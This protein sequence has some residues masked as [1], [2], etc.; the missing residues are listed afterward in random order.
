M[1]KEKLQ[2]SLFDIKSI[3][4]EGVVEVELKTIVD[5]KNRVVEVRDSFAKIKNSNFHYPENQKPAEIAGIGESQSGTQSPNLTLNDSIS[6]STIV[7]RGNV[8]N[9]YSLDPRGIEPPRPN[10]QG[11]TRPR[12]GPRY[13]QYIRKN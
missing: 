11:W 8:D 12:P 1:K 13:V 7:S 5:L 4:E 9:F 10:C 6:N 3:N 2:F